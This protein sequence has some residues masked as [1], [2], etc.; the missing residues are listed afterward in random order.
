MV[1]FYEDMRQTAIEMLTEFGRTQPAHL[2]PPGS[3]PAD[4]PWA[5]S[6]VPPEQ[7]DGQPATIVV[8]EYD[9]TRVRESQVRATDKNVLMAATDELVVTDKHKLRIDGKD[10][11]IVRASPLQPGDIVLLWDLQVRGA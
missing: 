10:F 1:S 2:I 8:L 5:D 4:Q 7:P 11:A 6:S 3:E 9:M